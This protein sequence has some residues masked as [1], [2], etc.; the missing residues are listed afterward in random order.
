MA[1]RLE[2]SLGEER[3]S[4]V[5]GCESDS[6]QLPIPDGPLTVGIDGG[7]IRGQRKEGKFEVIAGKNMPSFRRDEAA[8][9]LDGKCFAFVHTLGTKPRR[10]LF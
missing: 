6:Q 4:F 8:S 2:N 10:R 1:E 7:Y 3:E 5:E 9:E